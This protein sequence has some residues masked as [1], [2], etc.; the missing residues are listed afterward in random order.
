M[1]EQRIGRRGKGLAAGMLGLMLLAFTGP[2]RS[3]E[4][5]EPEVESAPA[6]AA[7]A[8][9]T[10][11]TPYHVVDGQIDLETVE[12]WKVYRGI[13]T[14]ATCHGPVGQGGVGPALVESMKNTVSK[15]LF[16]E[17]VT[18][19]RSGTM[20]KPFG[21]NKV[22]M[23]NLDRIY[24]YLKARADGVVGPGNLIKTPLGFE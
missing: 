8:A 23:D 11:D 24:A 6:A 2:A 18:R 17:T 21:A 22:V 13:G 20:M 16:V 19:G 4:V 1:L 3:D 5:L 7:A 10:A 15:E 14:C 12:G 9:S